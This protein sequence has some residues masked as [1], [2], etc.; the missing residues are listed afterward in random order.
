MAAL[1]ARVGSADVRSPGPGGA[2][3]LGRR[4]AWLRQSVGA[5]AAAA[6]REGAL[7]S[8][9]R[10]VVARFSRQRR[11]VPG[12]SGRRCEKDTAT[13]HGGSGYRRRQSSGEFE[14]GVGGR[15]C[16]GSG[17]LV[18]LQVVGPYSLDRCLRL[19][20]FKCSDVK[21]DDIF[22]WSE[23]QNKVNTISHQ[24]I[25]CR[26]LHLQHLTMQSVW[27]VTEPIHQVPEALPG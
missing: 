17:G 6:A 27:H 15:G 26:R 3:R 16:T 23:N 5:A 22:L 2:A 8:L 20:Q 7:V 12:P 9:R 24:E 21:S 18:L 11:V 19:F 25:T 13:V 10:T 14:L 4:C 1:A